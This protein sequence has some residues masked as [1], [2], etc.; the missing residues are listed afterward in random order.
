MRTTAKF[1]KPDDMEVE[2]TMR[3]TL[4]DWKLLRRS[5]SDVWPASDLSRHIGDV[6]Q[7]LEAV[8]WA[9]P[10]EPKG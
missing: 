8:V 2:L 1:L 10:E 6:V 5:L 9:T 4:G 3:M 7:K